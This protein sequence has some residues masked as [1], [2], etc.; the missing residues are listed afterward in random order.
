MLSTD[1]WSERP[2]RRRRYGHGTGLNKKVVLIN[3]EACLAHD[4]VLS[5]GC[6]CSGLGTAKWA[7]DS[8]LAPKCIPHRHVFMADILAA[9]RSFIM[10]NHQDLGM[11]FSD[12]NSATFR[13]GCTYVDIF[14]AGFSCQPFSSAGGHQ[15]LADD[16]SAV[17]DSI[18]WYVRTHKPKAWILENVKG[19]LTHHPEQ[20]LKILQTLE[21]LV[22]DDGVALYRISW[23]ILNSRFVGYVPHNRERL[24]IVGLRSDCNAAGKFQWPTRVPALPLDSVLDGDGPVQ[25]LSECFPKQ[26]SSPDGGVF[27]RNVVAAI[28][29]FCDR[30][31]HGRL[32]PCHLKDMVVDD[33]GTKYHYNL[34]YSPCLTAGR[35]RAGYWLPAKGR[36]LRWQEMAKLQGM[37]R[38]FV[39]NI[40]TSTLGFMLGNSFTETVMARLIASAAEHC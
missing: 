3:P 32:K 25:T 38:D 8:A 22:D 40:A 27:F 29:D 34:E 35:M 4:F 13:L 10:D 12:C 2:K 28:A 16:R 23:K 31:H 33:G 11:L 1:E 39:V 19:L 37:R 26:T 20:L 30:H 36:R 18:V 15:G 5:I 6:V 7:S 21:A 14:V 9:A 24:Y 17:I